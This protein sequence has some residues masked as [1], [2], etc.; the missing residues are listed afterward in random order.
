[1]YRSEGISSG[2]SVTMEKFTGDNANA[3]E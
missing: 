3:H 2:T 1:V